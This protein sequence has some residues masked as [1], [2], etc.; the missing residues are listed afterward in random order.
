M[1]DDIASEAEVFMKDESAV[2]IKE[3][4]KYLG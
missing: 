4:F 1:I 2:A 3:E